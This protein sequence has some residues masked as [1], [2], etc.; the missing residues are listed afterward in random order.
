MQLYLTKSD[1]AW[2]PV[3]MK[4]DEFGKRIATAVQSHSY[5]AN[6]SKAPQGMPEKNAFGWGY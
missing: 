4:A 2:L 5:G 6:G 1:G 3:T